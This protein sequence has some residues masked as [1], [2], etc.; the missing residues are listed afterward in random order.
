M[1]AQY[2]TSIFDTKDK[3]VGK[4]VFFV[5]EGVQLRVKFVLHHLLMVPKLVVFLKKLHV[6][7]L[8]QFTSLRDDLWGNAVFVKEANAISVELKKRVLFQFRLLTDTLYS[9]VP[10]G[11]FLL[12][13][14]SILQGCIILQN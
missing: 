5:T 6:I 9:P 2:L 8:F 4:T 7:V 13:S 3:D 12:Y 14:L 1:G 11:G 10:N